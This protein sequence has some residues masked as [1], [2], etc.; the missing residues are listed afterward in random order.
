M[1]RFTISKNHLANMIH[2]LEP[3]GFKKSGDHYTLDIKNEYGFED[4]AITVHFGMVNIIVYEAC[5]IKVHGCKTI[6]DLK[7][8]IEMLSYKVVTK[9]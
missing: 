2:K 8:L 9:Y 5:S 6:S 1:E 7:K 3:M 4:R